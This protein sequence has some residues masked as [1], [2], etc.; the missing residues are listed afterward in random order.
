MP[1]V[2]LPSLLHELTGGLPT[3]QATGTTLRA[4]INDID[5]QY[6]GLGERVVANGAIREDIMLAVGGDE[7]R[8][9]DTPVPPDAEVH[10][11]P[12][13]AGG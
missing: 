3:V 10:I 5:R 11:L 12:A 7:T 2:R 8:D 1:T 9:L 13:I 6:P 4:V